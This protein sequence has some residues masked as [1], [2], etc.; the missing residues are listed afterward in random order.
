MRDELDGRIWNEHHDQFSQWLD[1]VFVVAGAS[2]RRGGRTAA[3]VPG[4]LLAGLA[5]VTLT[6]TTFGASLA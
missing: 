6:L 3:R 1:G 2:L 4:Q 5:A